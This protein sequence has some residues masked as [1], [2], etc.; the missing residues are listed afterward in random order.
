MND[1]PWDVLIIGQG[2][3]GSLLAWQ[4]IQQ[5]YRVLVFSDGATHSASRMAAGLVNPVTGKRLV[6][7]PQVDIFL[8]RAIQLYRHLERHFGRRFFHEKDMLRVFNTHDNRQAWEKRSQDSDYEAYLGDLIQP[9]EYPSIN[10]PLGG[11]RQKQTGYLDTVSLLDSLDAFLKQR[12]AIHYTD[13]DYTDITFDDHGACVKNHPARQV[14]F[15]EGYKAIN[16]P[17]FDWLPFKPAKG[18][19]LTLGIVDYKINETVNAGHWLLPLTNGHYKFGASYQWDNLDE[20]PDETVKQ[21]LIDVLRRLLKQDNQLEILQH[22]AGIRPATRD[23]RPFIGMHPKHPRLGIFNGFGS[24]GSLMIP[25]Y[26]QQ[27]S[28]QLGSQAFDMNEADIRRYWK[29]H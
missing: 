9:D 28:A 20:V 2:L 26:S 19:I 25:Y 14:I 23:T 29:G 8:P 5:G 15:C 22:D 11:F 1:S 18:E 3:A 12:D 21:Q 6:K 7:S 13:V 27:F 17:W 24:K 4:L 16:N 10:M